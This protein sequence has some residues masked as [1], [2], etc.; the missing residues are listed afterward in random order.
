MS[1]WN[2]KK[3]AE[4]RAAFEDFLKYLQIDSK[5]TGVGPLTLYNAQKRFLDEVFAGLEND[6][7]FF[8]VLKARQLGISTITRAL[9]LFWNFMHGGLR[10]ALIYD[11]D[12]NKED[13]RKEM[14]RFYD[15]LPESHRIGQTKHDRYMF[16]FDNG[17]LISYFVAGIKKTKG[18]GGLGRSRGINVAGATEISSWGDIEGL[19]AFER[20]LAQQFPDRLYIFESTARGFNIFYDMVEEAKSDDL[21]K[22]FIFIGWWAKEIY[23]LQRDSA[24]FARYGVDPPDETEQRKIDEVKRLYN[25]T[26]TQEQL[27]WYRHET[28]PNVEHRSR[29]SEESDEIL[30]QEL[31]WTEQEAFL[32]SGSQFFPSE[33]LTAATL[34]ATKENPKAY[35][36]V[37]TD[38]FTSTTIKE[39]RSIKHAQLLVWEE[40]DPSGVYVLGADPAYGSSE[41]GDQYCIQVLRCY[42]DGV[43]QV[44]EFCTK[45]MTTYQFAWV[46]A[47]LCGAY[48]NARLLLELNGPGSAVFNAFRELETLI[49]QGYLKEKAEE[50][51]FA[52]IFDN[53]RQYLWARQD[54]LSRNP[55]A[56]HFETNT[57]RKIQI[58]ERLRDFFHVRQ[59][60]V[61]SLAA[62]AEMKNIVRNG[63]SIQGDGASHDDRV[64]GLALAIRAWEDSER[65]RLIMENRTREW[66]AKRRDMTQADMYKIWN[67]SIVGDFFT[68]QRRDRVA[69]Q[70]RVRRG[71]RYNW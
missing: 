71:S 67:D 29:D 39:A 10:T 40:P 16:G 1:G 6:I 28:D 27:A 11:T 57:K 18:S 36:Y 26:V 64:M 50:Q 41:D 70:R 60:R 68:R 62:L 37:M 38:E 8:V 45:M 44:A 4:F 33:K 17:S 15:G 46:I 13:A 25:Y 5:E 51:G 52:N 24:L 32:L 9:L 53:V 3:V 12:S 47:H 23:A 55:T 20:S 56:F 43:D 65:R 69:E 54:T 21:T 61:R 22:K 31:P 63:D 34:E 42:A 30:Q 14:Q 48:A 58:M 66:E 59:L 2:K 19:R 35:Y 49:K 7:H